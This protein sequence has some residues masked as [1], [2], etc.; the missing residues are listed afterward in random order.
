MTKPKPMTPT[1]AHALLAIV[2]KGKHRKPA[3]V[4]EALVQT[5]DLPRCDAKSDA[6]KANFRF[7]SEAYD[8][9]TGMVKETE[10][11]CWQWQ[12]YINKVGAPWW[13]AGKQSQPVRR[14]IYNLMHPNHAVGKW[15]VRTR[16]D[17]P[18]C[19][20]PDCLVKVSRSAMISAYAPFTASHLAAITHARRK[21][22]KL[23]ADTVAQILL[24]EG[25]HSAIARHVGC[26]RS[27][28]SRIKQGVSWVQTTPFTGLGA[29]SSAR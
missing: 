19:V 29:R 23:N 25:P 24:M 12:G 1:E 15:V 14:S 21:R 18:R 6:E 27:H 20:H 4:L 5:G 16:C 22:G 7:E 26:S 11:G 2:A 3:V 28:V 10:S 13:R 8:R 9:L 17:T